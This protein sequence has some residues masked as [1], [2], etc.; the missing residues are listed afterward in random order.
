MGF[1]HSASRY[2]RRSSWHDLRLPWWLR[3]VV[4]I[5]VGYVAVLWV[6]AV[7]GR[8]Q[9]VSA[10]RQ[11]SVCPAGPVGAEHCVAP[12]TG[13][14]RDK[15]TGESC[16]TDGNNNTQTCTTYY[17]VLLHRTQGRDHW[18]GVGS[19]TY[20]DVRS[21]DH[22]DLLTWHGAVV[23]MVVH[24]HTET[25]PPPAESSM[26]W[27]LA[28]LWLLLVVAVWA[29]LSGQL[30]LLLAF[31]N[32]GLV[33]LAMP[34]GWLVQGTL[35]GMNWLDWIFLVPFTAF[36]VF[37]TLAAWGV[38]PRRLLRRIRRWRP[39]RTAAPNG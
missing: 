27:P 30:S 5:A 14:V 13:D 29:A 3:V 18:V 39:R 20:R 10:Y 34:V 2:R 8:Y 26:F 17:D 38:G 33:W 37:W 6:G 22:A 19:R 24:G 11:A 15:R 21:G 16:T 23:R 31:P 9:D 28:G 4:L 35:L 25:Y 36:G 32:F 7:L 1:S 12:D